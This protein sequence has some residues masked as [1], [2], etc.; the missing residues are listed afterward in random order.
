MDLVGS[1]INSD[2]SHAEVLRPLFSGTSGSSLVQAVKSL[3]EAIAASQLECDDAEAS[4][5]GQDQYVQ[6]RRRHMEPGWKHLHG[7]NK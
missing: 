1:R 5:Q 6:K 3:S 4:R 7:K 2:G